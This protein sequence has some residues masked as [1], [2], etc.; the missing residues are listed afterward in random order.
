MDP[1]GGS[2]G[3]V[4]MAWYVK[5]HEWGAVASLTGSKL[6]TYFRHYQK[7]FDARSKIFHTSQHWRGL[8]GQNFFCAT[9]LGGAFRDGVEGRRG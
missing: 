1:V 9:R 8:Q 6:W 7:K 5:C 4:V 2:K 3:A